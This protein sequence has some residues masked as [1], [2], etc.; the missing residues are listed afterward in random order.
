MA[1]QL[2]VE[3]WSDIA[4]PWC[5]VGKR[6]LEAALAKFPHREQVKVVWRA[7]E[8]DPAAPAVRDERE[9]YVE[10]LAKKYGTVPAQASA[11][12]QRMVETGKAEGLALDFERIRSGNTFT[13]H[14]LLQLARE[15]GKQDALE[16][17][18]FAAYLS[19]G[20]K[21][22]DPETLVR[23]AVEAGLDLDEVTALVSTDLYAAEVRAEQQEARQIG[24][25][26]V[27]F[28]LLGRRYA[29]PGAQP[30]ELLLEALHKTWDE[31]SE[32]FE[33]LGSESDSDGEHAVCGP[34]GCT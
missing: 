13:A 1:K 8:L 20:E 31:Q 30:S 3:V 10:R 15:R 22:G 14:R 6:R 32:S 4:C 7:F 18:F 16:E 2:T 21:I 25:D 5:Y 17:R 34:D 33:S 27:P 26:G 23:L 19:E 12:I 11:M 28:F 24:V 29:V 9:S